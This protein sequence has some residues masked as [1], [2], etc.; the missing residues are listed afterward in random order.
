MIPPRTQPTPPEDELE[1]TFEPDSVAVFIA[2]QLERAGFT[3]E[4][5]WLL[6][7]RAAQHDLDW[8]Q[9]VGLLETGRWTELEILKVL[10]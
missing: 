3:Q 5:A 9:A 10:V 7:T 1:I 8:H 4:N 6:A 2:E